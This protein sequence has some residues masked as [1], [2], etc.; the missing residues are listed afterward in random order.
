VPEIRRIDPA[1]IF[2]MLKA[3]GCADMRRFPWLE[4]P[5][6]PA[7]ARAE[8]LLRDLGAAHPGT[9]E[10]TELGQRMVSFPVQPRY[11]RM[12]MAG[13]TYGCTR[14]AALIAAL[15]QTQDILLRR[16]PRHI[17][18]ARERVLGERSDSDFFILMLAWRYAQQQ[19]YRLEACQRLGIHAGAARQVA[20]LFQQF[21]RVA[22]QQGLTI[23]ERSAS[24]EA[25]RKCILTAFID[26]LA[27]RRDE[28][29]LRCDLVHGRRGELARDSAVRHSRLFVA[30]EIDEIE[31]GN[32]ELNVILRL[33]TAVDE[34]WL[35]ELFPTAFS[36]RTE[37][38]FDV[39]GKRVI[40]KQVTLFRD[41]VLRTKLAGPPSEEAAAAL[42]AHAVL[43]GRFTL[44]HWT[45][46]VDQWL[47]RLNGLTRWCP[48]LELT[49]IGEADRLFLLEQICLGSFSAKEIED[50]PVW[51]ALKA[52]LTPEQEALLEAYAPERFLLPCGRSARIRYAADAPPVLSA[53]IQDLYGLTQTPAIAMG[54]QPLVVEILAPNQRPV[55]VTQDLAGFWTHTYPALK[56]ELQKRYPKHEWR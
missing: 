45:P 53:R 48:E 23:N 2:L 42:L 26:Q 21:L 37:V 33:A 3:Q 43:T 54:R 1:E 16:Q 30:A 10:I 50:K 36:E 27:L 19:G 38:A 7:T 39:S 40:S 6:E 12:L 55:Q 20:P 9:G 13:H 56:K 46:A 15:T 5:E 22:E 4:A 44:K 31:H 11:A 28:G 14:E 35:L 24:Q 29:T 51:P 47:Y 25:M 41:V 52:W 17:Q 18:E 34:A 49:S 32:R 8:Q